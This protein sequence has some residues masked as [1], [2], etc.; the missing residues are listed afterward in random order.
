MIL[1]NPGISHELKKKLEI[2]L[3]AVRIIALL[4]IIMNYDVELMK[5]IKPLLYEFYR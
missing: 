3:V 5:W 2:L 1:S 4:P